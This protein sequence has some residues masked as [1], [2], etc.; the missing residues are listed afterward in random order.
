GALGQFQGFNNSTHE[1]RI[2]NIASG[3]T[4]NFMLGGTSRFLVNNDGRIRLGV[5]A[6]LSGGTTGS[7][8]QAAG[9]TPPGSSGGGVF[10]EGGA[11]LGDEGGGIYLD[12]N[13]IAM[14]SPGDADLL[15]I[16]DEDTIVV[17]ANPAI[18]IPRFVVDAVGNI[19]VGAGATG[20][21]MDSDNTIIAG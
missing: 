3:G 11:S 18:T 12:G 16:Y 19:R 1:Y 7:R 17:P 10:I 13:T 5:Q 4:I 2:N 6:T 8:G 9:W 14:W 21:V 20:C 15:R